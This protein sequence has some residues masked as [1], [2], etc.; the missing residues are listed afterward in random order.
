[1]S[2]NDE[3]K[4][5][6]K[7]GCLADANSLEYKW[8]CRDY[9]MKNK[10]KNKNF[11]EVL[12]QIST[13]S[14]KYYQDN[15]KNID[16][17]RSL[18]RIVRM[19]HCN[20]TSETTK[21]TDVKVT[22]LAEYFN[23]MVNSSRNVLACYDC[24]TVARATFL[25]LINEYRVPL[26][27]KEKEQVDYYYDSSRL[28]PI[29][30]LE[31]FKKVFKSCKKHTICIASIG[32]DGIDGD[33]GFGHIWCFEKRFDKNRKPIYIMYQSCLNSYLMLDYIE[34]MSYGSKNIT[35]LDIDEFI[36]DMRILI[37]KNRWTKKENDIFT[38]WFHFKPTSKVKKVSSFLFAC[39]DLEK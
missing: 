27:L 38:N 17:D 25:E 37:K 22:N 10:T 12:R 39:V 31:D 24:G 13:S 8:L 4:F 36:K 28:K 3:L 19:C 33:S 6:K 5:A 9:L 14:F 21:C 2:K 20:G 18:R 1:M 35:G 26:T 29:D 15:H 30:A 23:D 34:Y 32:M 11:E 16:R 7:V